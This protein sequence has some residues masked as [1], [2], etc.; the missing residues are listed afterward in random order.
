MIN[1][2]LLSFARV[3]N[4]GDF[5]VAS[6]SLD[7]VR[8]LEPAVHRDGRGTFLRAHCTAA[9][10]GAGVSFGTHVQTN[11]SRSVQGT[12]RGLH[13]RQDLRES[14]I[15]HVTHGEV[16]DVV[17]DL[18]PWSPTFLRWESFTLD[19][20]S[21]RQVAIPPGCAHGFQVLTPEADIAYYV[22]APYDAAADAALAW[23][24]P[25][26]AIAWPMD[27]PVL[28]ERDRSAPTLRDALADIRR[29]YRAPAPAGR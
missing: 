2:R 16:F 19:D 13:L 9:L 26:L 21:H 1:D 15:V 3:R 22:D 5:T 23:N 4:M 6:T 14:K 20:V 18:R 27:D 11:Q 10:T 25:D 28:S 29:W 24:D 12:L 8:T 7:G 17:V